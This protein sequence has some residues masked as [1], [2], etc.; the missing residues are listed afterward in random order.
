MWPVNLTLSWHSSCHSLSRRWLQEATSIRH[1]YWPAAI[2]FKTS[3]QITHWVRSG[4]HH[5]GLCTWRLFCFCYQHI[6]KNIS[7]K[8]MFN[9]GSGCSLGRRQTSLHCSSIEVISPQ[10]LRLRCENFDRHCG[11]LGQSGLRISRDCKVVRGGRG[12]ARNHASFADD[13]PEVRKIDL[14][15]H[16]SLCGYAVSRDYSTHGSHD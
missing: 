13:A 3:F 15:C 8:H 6:T 10:G 16:E 14:I 11:L 9:K 7:S 4:L 2:A 12:H 5:Q 1:W